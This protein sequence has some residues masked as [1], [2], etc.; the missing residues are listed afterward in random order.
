LDR[1]VAL[2]EDPHET[3]PCGSLVSV[4]IDIKIE[5]QVELAVAAIGEVTEVAAQ[6]ADIAVHQLFDLMVG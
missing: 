4:R 5:V 3:Q 6:D 1:R 2:A